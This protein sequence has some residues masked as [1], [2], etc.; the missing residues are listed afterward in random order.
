MLLHWFLTQLLW[1][2]D[3]YLCFESEFIVGGKM[4]LHVLDRRELK[5]LLTDIDRALEAIDEEN[6]MAAARAAQDAASRFGLSLAQLV[7]DIGP[8]QNEYICG[9]PRYRNPANPTQTWTGRGRR[10]K[11][12]HGLEAAGLS[13]DDAAIE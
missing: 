12:V 8:V 1:Q 9:V 10:P 3:M 7:D 13:L 11:W 4:D 6:R 5:K 2:L